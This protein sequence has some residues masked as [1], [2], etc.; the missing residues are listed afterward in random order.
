MKY[1]LCD[2]RLWPCII[3]CIISH[4][5]IFLYSVIYNSTNTIVVDDNNVGN[6]MNVAY[7]TSSVD[8]MQLSLRWCIPVDL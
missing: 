5:D 1:W 4:G 2:S 7:T 3:F 8:H 6:I